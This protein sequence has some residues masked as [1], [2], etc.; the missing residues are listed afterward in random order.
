MKQPL[1]RSNFPTID[2]VQRIVA[3][4][5]VEP[6]LGLE[7]LQAGL[8][9]TFRMFQG[10]RELDSTARR[11]AYDDLAKIRMG[12]HRLRSYFDHTERKRHIRTHLVAMA[13]DIGKRR[14]GY[15]ELGLELGISEIL[16]EQEPAS[17]TGGDRQEWNV[18]LDV[19]ADQAVDRAVAGVNL[20]LEWSAAAIKEQRPQKHDIS[21]EVRL[22]AHMLPRLFEEHFGQ[23]FTMN[24][25]AKGPSGRGFAF[26]MAVIDEASQAGIQ[27]IP[28]SEDTIRTYFVQGRGGKRRRKR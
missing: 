11:R 22:V 5:G 18:Q 12:A 10:Y 6:A 20:L 25:A 14:C 8:R 26:E 4:V 24:T 9:M 19:H 17:D 23:K 7:R 1:G 2:A 16:Y 3:A 27:D 15:P 13:A 21:P 28:C